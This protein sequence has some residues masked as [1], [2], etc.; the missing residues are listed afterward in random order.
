MT[1][2]PISPAADPVTR[3]RSALR[4]PARHR[5][6][7]RRSRHRTVAIALVPML[8]AGL[9]A[10]AAPPATA[11]SVLAQ[12]RAGVVD[13]TNDARRERGCPALKTHAKLTRAAQSHAADMSA[14]NYFEHDSRDG[15]PWDVRI[16]RAGFKNPAGENLAGGYLTAAE[17]VGAWRDSTGHRS[18]LVDCR[19]RY[20][21]VGYRAD[22]HYWVQD[23]G[24]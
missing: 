23:F 14:N 10:V 18:N 1:P 24:Y 8:A 6:A 20:I 17:V 15:T 3:R 2:A 4:S 13:L 16:Q 19:F 11:R 12:M 22:G 7:P 9:L 21:G 5:R